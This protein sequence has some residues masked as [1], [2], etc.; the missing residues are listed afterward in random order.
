MSHDREFLARTVTTVVELDLAQQQ[1]STYGGGYEAYLEE[2]AVAR[3]HAREAFEE[4]DDTRAALVERG[5]EQRAWME[6]GVKNARRKAPD[7]DKIGRKFRTEA[8]EKQAAKARQ[9]QRRI[10]RLEVVEE[11][12]KEW[13]LRME[14]AAAPRAGAVVATA[15]RVVVR[16]P[17]FVLG[18]VD[19][20]LDWGDRV[21][22][23]GANGSG[24]STLLS[25]LLGRLA[26]DEGARLAR[27]G[28]RRRRGRPGARG[29]RRDAD[30]AR[31]V[32]RPPPRPRRTPRSARCSPSSA[33]APPTCT[34]PATP[35]PPVSGPGPRSRCSRPAASTCSCSTSRPTTWTCRRSSSWSRPSRTSA[36]RCVLVTHDRRMLDAVR[37]T[38]RLEVASG[39][40]TEH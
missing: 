26:P 1:V 17:G 10:E 21:V 24:K 27:A 7:N 23:T 8:T 11:P 12:R 36:A 18:P 9:T 13:E 39:R 19:L 31:D 37:S 6:K 20:Q 33:S 22:L 16:R 4:Y 28:C 2:R 3:R 35:S 29:V 34:A 15:R 38:R 5:R 32:R 40:V 14:I 25:V 30:A